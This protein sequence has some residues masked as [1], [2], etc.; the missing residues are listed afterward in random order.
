MARLG[1]PRTRA[2]ASAPGAS[3]RAGAAG[4]GA[5][6]RRGAAARAARH[7]EAG[8]T[9]HRQNIARRIAEIRGHCEKKKKKK[10]KLHNN[11]EATMSTKKRKVDEAEPAPTGQGEAWRV[12]LLL[13]VFNAAHWLATAL[14]SAAAAATRCTA[15]VHVAAYDDGSSDDRHVHRTPCA[16]RQLTLPI[17]PFLNL[18]LVPI[19]VARAVWPRF[20]VRCVRTVRCL[21]RAM[22]ASTARVRRRTAWRTRAMRPRRSRASCSRRCARRRRTRCLCCSTPTIGATTSLSLSSLFSFSSSSIHFSVLSLLSSR[23]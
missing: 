4:R 15:P 20:G 5:G 14:R 23:G 7:S 17:V 8:N 10:K 12:V 16:T 21:R 19:L 22:C 1:G 2:R 13:P 6:R 9:T 3:A 11:L 18:P